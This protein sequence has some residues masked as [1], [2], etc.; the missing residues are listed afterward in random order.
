M[1]Q[2]APSA[3]LSDLFKDPLFYKLIVFESLNV[4][5]FK[6]F[7]SHYFKKDKIN[8][9]YI[10]IE[11]KADEIEANLNQTDRRLIKENSRIY[12]EKYK[13]ITGTDANVKDD[14]YICHILELDKYMK[15]KS[16]QEFIDLY[17][18]TYYVNLKPVIF[19]DLR[20]I[21]A[22]LKEHESILDNTIQQLKIEN[23]KDVL[24]FLKLRNDEDIN[25]VYNK[26]FKIFL[27]SKPNKLGLYYQ[28]ND[29]Q[30]YKKNVHRSQ[31]YEPIYEYSE[32]YNDEAFDDDLYKYKYL[33]GQFTQIFD[34][35]LKNQDI[36]TNMDI[37]KQS[38]TKGNDVFMIGYGASGA[39][40]TSTLVYLKTAQVEENGIVVNICNQL[41][42]TFEKIELSSIELY[43]VA[44]DSSKTFETK[45][46]PQ[47]VSG[48]EKK[49]YS[50]VLKDNQFVAKTA[51]D[52]QNNHNNEIKKFEKDAQIGS[53]IIHMI[54]SDRLIYGTTNNPKS[55]R[56]HALIFLKLIFKKDKKPPSKN[57][58]YLIIGDFA[59]VENKFDCEK[60]D[61]IQKFSE[62]NVEEKNGGVT[63]KNFAYKKIKHGGG[64]KTKKI[65]GGTIAS[66]TNQSVFKD[67]TIDDTQLY[68]YDFKKPEFTR[69]WDLDKELFQKVWNIIKDNT[70][71]F[72]NLKID[73]FLTM[74]EKL[75]EFKDADKTKKEKEEKKR[76]ISTNIQTLLN[77]INTF[78]DNTKIVYQTR[79]KNDDI[80][81]F[82][83]SIISAQ[84]QMSD[85]IKPIII[86]DKIK[87]IQ[88]NFD[89]KQQLG[90]FIHIIKEIN[91]KYKNID[92]EDKNKI[93]IQNLYI[94]KGR[95]DNFLLYNTK[96]DGWNNCIAGKYLFEKIIYIFYALPT[97]INSLPPEEKSNGVNMFNGKIE[98]NEYD[99]VKQ[100]IE[101]FKELF[102]TS[103]AN[104][105]KL[106]EECNIR[107]VEGKFIN[108]SLTDL[109]TIIKGIISK[110]NQGI[111]IPN[112][113]GECF[114]KYFKDDYFKS[115]ILSQGKSEIMNAI[116]S[117][118]YPTQTD[119]IINKF[120]TDLI[121]SIFCVFNISRGAN[122]PPPTHYI[123]I[124]K[125]KYLFST[126]P[127]DT[128]MP[129]LLLSEINHAIDLINKY[130]KSLIDKH[131][132]TQITDMKD[133]T[134]NDRTINF[135]NK[136]ITN[137]I[138]LID[139][140]NAPSA[141]GTLEF[142]DSLAK[143]NT[144]E[145]ICRIDTSFTTETDIIAK[146]NMIELYSETEQKPN[147]N[148]FNNVLIKESK[149][150]SQQQTIDE[151]LKA[152]AKENAEA[153]GEAKAK[154]IAEAKGEAKGEKKDEAK[155]EKKD[156]AKGETKDEHTEQSVET[157]SAKEKHEPTSPKSEEELIK[158]AEKYDDDGLSA[159]VKLGDMYKDKLDKIDDA[160]KYYEKAS[161]H[162]SYT[163]LIDLYKT[164]IAEST[165]ENMKSNINYKLGLIYEYG[166]D[167][168]INI[169]EAIK[170]YE[171]SK[172]PQAYR[173]RALI[174]S[175]KNMPELF[176]LFGEAWKGGDT[177]VL[178]C[179]IN[180][181]KF[182]ISTEYKV[183]L[184]KKGVDAKHLP[185]ILSD[186]LL[187]KIT[188]GK[189]SNSEINTEF[190]EL[191]QKNETIN[192]EKE[193]QAEDENEEAQ[194]ILFINELKK[195]G[196]TYTFKDK[197]KGAYWLKKS[198]KNQYMPALY[199]HAF[200]PFNIALFP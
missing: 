112:F 74:L 93:E 154:E 11:L 102:E 27:N 77:A 82:T 44:N 16:F 23:N 116:I 92:I 95:I 188:K 139:N 118:I 164:K 184:I 128:K 26:R 68:I 136:E 186:M 48:Q 143:Y 129:G 24:T 132:Y 71:S 145:N 58:V 146:N 69:Q 165:D 144:I 39:G 17:K 72:D 14:V 19:N 99:N 125:L 123:D 189:K 179:I 75:E 3:I 137:F 151:R 152:K 109:R 9:I 149:V 173:R 41:S 157:N 141:V 120:Y 7:I 42:D 153:K 33:F 47:I 94:D 135:Y 182:N 21:L 53:V 133:K 161:N 160:I 40:K 2:K 127:K 49:T 89:Q 98:P 59:G 88:E 70:R 20:E 196:D 178:S 108:N 90:N 84:K 200:E 31:D 130:G 83:D 32:G 86:D 96:S 147:T 5:K 170:C 110:K 73:T 18:D 197:E 85:I 181:N 148:T 185:C 57:H 76:K 22:K 81:K 119:E 113:I 175:N 43:G 168:T 79:T 155:G 195:E 10:K 65:K 194:F 6:R 162:E 55:S 25:T 30:Y 111:V 12:S 104:S 101:K 172:M 105:A 115:K 138:N 166:K 180:N 54:D 158:Q 34:P 36:A 114:D 150:K 156:E 121:I 63:V 51:F 62:I 142:L 8:G 163:K 91:Q 193:K 192:S 46:S 87:I 50:F 190:I 171:Q 167:G 35:T 78:L 107:V 28:I 140:F 103:K 100:I 60:P 131:E 52:H 38:L 169:A 29:N 67:V 174:S 191:I 56:S 124:N 126:N 198:H 80:G 159:C 4:E 117:E 1:E 61:V 183:E 199:F 13:V 187:Q 177:S 97:Y 64:R 66:T 106:E 176:K 45:R 15:N 122:N 134:F 37:I